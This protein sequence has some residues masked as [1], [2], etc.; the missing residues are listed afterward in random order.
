MSYIL[1]QPVLHDWCNKGCGMCY[2]VCGIVH[3]KEP[4]L[5]IEKSSPCGSSGFPL[6]LSEWS[7]TIFLTPYNCYDNNNFSFESSFYIIPNFVTNRPTWQ[8]TWSTDSCLE[9]SIILPESITWWQLVA[10]NSMLYKC[11]CKIK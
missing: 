5:L 3:I 6:L 4:L 2:P 10:T 7:F 11:K 9:S 8:Y 1:F